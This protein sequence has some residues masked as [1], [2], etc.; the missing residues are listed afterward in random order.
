MITA[1]LRL[2]ALAVPSICQNSGWH[3]DSAKLEPALLLYCSLVTVALQSGSA[4]VQSGSSL[5]L[6]ALLY[7][8]TYSIPFLSASGRRA[9]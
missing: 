5:V 6:V 3:T 1:H 2:G 9:I 4:T 8:S 7:R